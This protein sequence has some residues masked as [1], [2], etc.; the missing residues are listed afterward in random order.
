M[1]AAGPSSRQAPDLKRGSK[2]ANAALS[3]A[4][5]RRT[6]WP[7][8]CR[9]RALPRPRS[10]V[11]RSLRLE[12]PPPW[13]ALLFIESGDGQLD[14]A[15]AFLTVTADRRYTTKATAWVPSWP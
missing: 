14:A 9:W 11:L 4:A 7:H 1:S 13:S 2:L 15:A 5:A 6:G 3:A 12:D 10:S 8:R